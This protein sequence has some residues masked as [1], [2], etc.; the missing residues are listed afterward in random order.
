MTLLATESND[1]FYVS[2]LEIDR[3]GYTYTIDTIH[4]LQEIY[5]PDTEIFFITGADA[6]YQMFSWH[7]AEEAS[8]LLYLC[9]RNT[10]RIQQ[11]RADAPDSYHS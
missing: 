4:A 7:N 10:S 8:G 3:V 1:D 6:F 11:R 2:R 5:G 9:R